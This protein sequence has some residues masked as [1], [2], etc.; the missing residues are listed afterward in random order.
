MR[1]AKEEDFTGV[2]GLFK[3]NHDMSP[4]I[5]MSYVARKIEDRRCNF[6][7]GVVIIFEIY[8]KSVQVCK[9]TKLRTYS[10]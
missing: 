10:F 6:S 9:N 5:R 4:H 2:Y 8:E 3:K 7:E 1:F